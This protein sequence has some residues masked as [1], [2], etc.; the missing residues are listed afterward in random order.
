MSVKKFHIVYLKNFR[1]G[2]HLA[3]G[4]TNS[5]DKTLDTLHSDSLKSAIFVC[6]LQL[7]ND[8]LS[9]KEQSESFFKKFKISSAFPY[10]KSTSANKVFHFFPKPQIPRLP[11][12]IKGQETGL[13]KKLKKVRY[14]EYSLF[15]RF[16]KNEGDFESFQKENLS[17]QFLTD[18]STDFTDILKKDNCNTIMTTDTYQ[19]VA[20]PRDYGSDST[21]YYVDKIYFHHNAGLFFLLEL[22]DENDT[23][24]LDKV[25]AGMR[26]L[27][28]SGIGTDR[29]SGN[30]QF[31]V[32]VDQSMSFDIA[33]NANYQLALSLYCPRKEEIS[34]GDKP[35]VMRS[36]YNLVKRGGHISSPQNSEHLTIRKRSIYM[37]TEGSI[38][39]HN[40]HRTGKLVNLRPKD[41]TTLH[42]PIWRDGQPIFIPMN[43]PKATD[44]E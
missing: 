7:F 24:T 27:A 23:D 28:D 29:N 16:L 41:F 33:E 34:T 2:L 20:I 10:Y 43:Y 17:G 14:L 4:L 19:H 38:F 44:N 22:E 31:E 11:F 32:D 42:H 8:Q 26:L 15:Q 35:D 6:A 37:F 18:T 39:P 12:D 3:R 40:H 13:E 5:Y 21:P 9:A 36:Y 1:G 30:G 25:Q